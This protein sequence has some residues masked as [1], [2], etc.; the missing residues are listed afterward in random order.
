MKI[1]RWMI[2][3]K[4]HCGAL[5]KIKLDD[6]GVDSEMVKDDIGIDDKGKVR[7]ATMEY[8][9]RYLQEWLEVSDDGNL[10]EVFESLD[11][12][13]FGFVAGYEACLKKI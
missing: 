13:I 7:I 2:E 4:E 6:I 11:L 5:V 8:C 10:T 12:V 1:A 9:V 3:D